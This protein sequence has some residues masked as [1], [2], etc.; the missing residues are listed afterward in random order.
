M[1]RRAARIHSERVLA[2]LLFLAAYA[3]SGLAGLIYEVSWTRLL[4]LYMGHTTAAAS[5]VVAAFMGGLAV[6]AAV[7]GR[8]ASRLSRRQCLVAYIALEALVVVVALL[9]PFEL[10]VFTAI[11]SACD[12]TSLPMHET[13]RRNTPYFLVSLT[14]AAAQG[15]VGSRWN[16]TKLALLGTISLIPT[17]LKPSMSCARKPRVSWYRSL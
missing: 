10:S 13:S 7:G 6:G 12:P 14:T 16:M 5:A 3:C 4:T 2:Q 15:C 8:I 1:A 11:L 9:L 17:S